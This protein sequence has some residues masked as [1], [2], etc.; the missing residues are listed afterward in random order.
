MIDFNGTIITLT[1][2]NSVF[3]KTVHFLN[4]FVPV[5]FLS[6]SSFFYSVHSIL[7]C[8]TS[9]PSGPGSR[10]R[11]RSCSR[12][13]AGPSASVPAGLLSARC[14]P[15]PRAA[16]LAGA[17]CRAGLLAAGRTARARRHRLGRRRRRGLRRLGRQRGGGPHRY[18]RFQPRPFAGWL[19]GLAADDVCHH[20]SGGDSGGV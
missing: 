14:C 20:L 17:C 5:I 7:A 15:V 4:F 19:G 3:S 6:R 12:P 13:W 1:V 9:G 10:L 8:F 2:W 18:H 11:A 16:G